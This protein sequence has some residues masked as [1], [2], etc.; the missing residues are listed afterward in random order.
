LELFLSDEGAGQEMLEGTFESF[1][2]D[3]ARS[4]CRLDGAVC[5]DVGAHV[6]Y[7]TLGFAALGADVVAFE[8]NAHN[9]RHLQ[10]H[11]QRN[12]TLA[13]RVKHLPVALAD[14][15]GEM[16]FI[17]SGDLGGASSG[18][19]LDTALP[20]LQCGAYASFERTRVLAARIDT[21]IDS[22]G[23]RAPDILKIDVE[24]AEALVLRGGERF[25]SSRKPVLLME[26]HHIRL[27][28]EVQAMLLRWGYLIEL[29]DEEHAIPSRCFIAAF[30][31]PIS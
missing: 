26:V 12:S 28:M 1:L 2:Y 21:L 14:Y 22:G 17:Q 20:P 4:R 13:R 19:H 5:W 23:A 3:A 29:L 8:P 30:A 10:M 25:F 24:G 16:T 15:D 11:L 7:H 27:M 9:A 31:P 18:S 6:G